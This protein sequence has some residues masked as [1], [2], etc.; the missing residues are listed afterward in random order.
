M[1]KK[2]K[3]KRVVIQEEL[4]ALMG[5]HV[6]A[7]ILK[8]FLYWGERVRDFD[9]FIAEEKGRDPD[10]RIEL[11]RGWIYKSAEELADELMISISSRT[12]ARR[13]EDVVSAGWLDR[14]RNPY[15]AWDRTW[16][17]RPN[18]RKIQAGLRKL[19]YALEG[20]PV[21]PDVQCNGQGDESIGQ[22]DEAL[23]EITTEIVPEIPA[24][25]AAEPQPLKLDIN[26]STALKEYQNAF[27][28]LGSQHLFEKFQML[29]DEH[30]RLEVH[31]YARKEM[32]QAM[33][34]DEGHVRPNLGYYAQCLATGAARAQGKRK[35]RQSGAKRRNV[36]KRTAA[37][38]EDP[39]IKA[40]LEKRREH[41]RSD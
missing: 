17:Y 4:V 12:L 37:D 22:G 19:G 8:Q 28:P 9:K 16:Q 10:T 21:L 32:Y 3:L 35:E 6:N 30:S 18:L 40:W 27:G 26:F 25:A 41:G 36:S 34:R 2:R 23:P 39:D 14:R 24:E 20:Y 38:P 33:M 13:I 7:L 31:Q 11:T 15:H 1:T 29:W 5:D